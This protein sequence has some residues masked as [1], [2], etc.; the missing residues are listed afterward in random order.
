MHSMDLQGRMWNFLP[1]AASRLLL[2]VVTIAGDVVLVI[3]LHVDGL[4]QLFAQE[5]VSDQRVYRL[6]LTTY[7]DWTR[8]LDRKVAGDCHLTIAGLG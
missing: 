7:A 1:R 6:L 5:R 3:G 4:H 2:H 8:M